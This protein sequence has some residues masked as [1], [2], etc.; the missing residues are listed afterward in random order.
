MIDNINKAMEILSESVLYSWVGAMPR[1]DKG[2]TL[3]STGEA[4]M[5]FAIKEAIELLRKEVEV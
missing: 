5:Y 1:P 3:V 4:H 2:A